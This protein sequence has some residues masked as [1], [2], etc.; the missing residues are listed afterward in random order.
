MSRVG[1][2]KIFT[3]AEAETLHFSL[4]A[5]RAAR[6]IRLGYRLECLSHCVL[7]PSGAFR[8]ESVEN[9]ICLRP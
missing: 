1:T 4:N 5:Y 2:C 8:A 9:V 6:S 3:E 7:H